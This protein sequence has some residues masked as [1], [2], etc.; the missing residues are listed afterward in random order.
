MHTVIIS[1]DI[2][3]YLLNFIRASIII[4]NAS[5]DE[6]HLDVGEYV[7]CNMMGNGLESGVVLCAVYYRTRLTARVLR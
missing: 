1:Q 6:L 2:A 3:P 7:Y 5:K 4:H